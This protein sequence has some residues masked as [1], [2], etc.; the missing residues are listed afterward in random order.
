MDFQKSTKRLRNERPAKGYYKNF[1][2]IFTTRFSH[3]QIMAGIVL[4][5]QRQASGKQTSKAEKQE[6]KKKVTFYFHFSFIA[7]ASLLVEVAYQLNF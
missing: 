3:A 7:F 5:W 1:F 6:S 2:K 4:R